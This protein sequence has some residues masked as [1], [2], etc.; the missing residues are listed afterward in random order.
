MKRVLFGATFC[1]LSILYGAGASADVTI[2]SDATQNITCSAG[3]CSPTSPVA[4]LN[5]GDLET[6]LAAGNV[7]VTT[8]GSGIQADNIGVDVPISWSNS[9][10]LQLDASRS[11]DVAASVTVAGGG[12]MQ[13]TSHSKALN[14]LRFDAGGSITFASLSSQLLINN[15][16]YQLVDSVSSLAAALK[17]KPS[18][19]FALAANY[20]ASGDGAYSSTPITTGVM[21]NVEGL[22]NTIANI[23]ISAKSIQTIAGLFS[24][25]GTNGAVKDLRLSSLRMKIGTYKPTESQAAGGLVTTNGGLLFGDN[26]SGEIS[27]NATNGGDSNLLGGLTAQNAGTIEN[28]SSS[29]AIDSK[30]TI[31]GGLVGSNSGSILESYATA[32]VRDISQSPLIVVGGFVGDNSG[33]IG[34]S[35]A[36]GSVTGQGTLEDEN[37]PAAGG[38]VGTS[39]GKVTNSY[40]TG[41][42]TLNLGARG[43]FSGGSVECSH[44]Y[45]D[46]STSGTKTGTGKGNEAGVSGETTKKLRSKLPKG[47]SP[48]VWAEGA[49]V[50]HGLPYLLG[51]TPPN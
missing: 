31:V 48:H 4:V 30:Q 35:Y 10:S 41:R 18:G 12:G 21:G 36:L 9:S 24:S 38:F 50:N 46:T 42:V 17:N 5:A 28:C 13:L 34:N 11:I 32:H 40:S 51:N 49:G 23:Q 15:S 1:A 45:W 8:A 7:T 16:S 29:A 44:C 43:G 26:V 39:E 19:N 14:S 20:D 2:S 6:L 27:V 47:L 25:V 3:V 22:G 37:E 33:H